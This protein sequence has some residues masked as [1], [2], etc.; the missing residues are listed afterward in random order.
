MNY[1][2][3]LE[4]ALL[5]INRLTNEEILQQSKMLK[6]PKVLSQIAGLG[7]PLEAYVH[8]IEL[9]LLADAL[10][11]KTKVVTFEEGYK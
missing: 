9:K 5:K 11:L 8:Q 1:R 6:N 3:H 4:R 10:W 2:E 7:D